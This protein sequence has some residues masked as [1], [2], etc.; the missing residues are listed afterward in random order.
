MSFEDVLSKKSAD[1]VKPP[2]IPA[3][4]YIAMVVGQPKKVEVGQDKTPCF[5]YDL[6]LLQPQDDVNQ[7]ELNALTGGFSN[8]S[9]VRARFFLTEKAAYRLKDFLTA[10]GVEE[11]DLTL[12]QR[13][14]QATGRQVK[15]LMKQSPSAD[16]QSVYSNPDS[17]SEA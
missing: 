13:A 16:G 15:V 4:T 7:D 9:P 6:K 5:D 17:Y 8:A 3:G 10:C 2:P 1:V 11:G 14:M 12:G